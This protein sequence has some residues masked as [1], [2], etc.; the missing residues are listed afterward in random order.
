[1]YMKSTQKRFATISTILS[2]Y[3]ELCW[4]V[5]NHVNNSVIADGGGGGERGEA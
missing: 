3:C 2:S 4:Q 5:N 1:M